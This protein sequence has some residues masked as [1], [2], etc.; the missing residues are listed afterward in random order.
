[1]RNPVKQLR[2]KLRWWL[3]SPAARRHKLVG[4]MQD[5]KRKREFQIFFLK[6]MGLQ[7]W[8]Y[9]MD[10][11][12]GTLRG[13]IPL[14]EFL[15]AGHY[16]GLESRLPSL[17]EGR[18]EL[19]EAGLESRAPQLLHSPDLSVVKLDR[20]FDFIWAFAVLIHMTDEILDGCLHLVQEHLLES[21]A[22]YANVNLGWRPEGRW[23][24]FPVV[25][26]CLEFYQ[27]A[28]QRRG[29]LVVDLGTSESFRATGIR[30]M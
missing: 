20:Q 11:G 8:H 5:W 16:Y 18:K 28:G 30:K 26:R 17:A 19:Q 24:G 27:Q 29:L 2:G 4:P 12:C 23:Q 3:A 10:I 7:P 22:F 15:E 1:M 6:L 25:G 21:G 14:I 9:L 13:G